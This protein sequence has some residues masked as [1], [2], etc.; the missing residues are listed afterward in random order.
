MVNFSGT[1]SSV[2]LVSVGAVTQCN[3][4]TGTG[5]TVNIERGTSMCYALN[6]FARSFSGAAVV[7]DTSGT[8]PTVTTLNLGIGNGGVVALNGWIASLTY[9]PLR[10]PNA[11]LQTLS[12]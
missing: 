11:T 3:I 5:Y 1:S 4:T 10:L 2:F 7:T 8:V 6:D 9:Y 12:T